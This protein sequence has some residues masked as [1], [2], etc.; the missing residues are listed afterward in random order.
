MM[1]GSLFQG[2]WNVYFSG[3]VLIISVALKVKK[4]Y[5]ILQDTGVADEEL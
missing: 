2:M 3:D 4:G 1:H 5:E